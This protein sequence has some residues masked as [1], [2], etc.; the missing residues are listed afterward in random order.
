MSKHSCGRNLT[1]DQLKEQNSSSEPETTP[2]NRAVESDVLA[3][4]KSWTVPS[5]STLAS[6]IPFF[7]V[8]LAL[9]PLPSRIP[10]WS[11]LIS[12]VSSVS[13]LSLSDLLL[14]LQLRNYNMAGYHMCRAFSSHGLGG[15][16]IFMGLVFRLF[17]STQ[18]TCRVSYLTLVLLHP[19]QNIQH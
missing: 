15:L 7:L 8:L 1:S 19:N 4:G 9:S 16:G 17:F 18:G 10:L 2:K 5:F 13:I 11:Q 14:I 12:Q 6:Q 3:R